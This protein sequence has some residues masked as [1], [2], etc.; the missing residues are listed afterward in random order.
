MIGAGH[1]VAQRIPTGQRWLSWPL[2]VFRSGENH[3]FVTH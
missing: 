2:F 1:G 3:L